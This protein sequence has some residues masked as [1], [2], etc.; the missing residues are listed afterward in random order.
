MFILPH[1]GA[2]NGD[3]WHIQA[4]SIMGCWVDGQPEAICQQRPA[5]SPPGT[6]VLSALGVRFKDH[7]V[8]I[9]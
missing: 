8:C 5:C 7:W 3:T 2:G 6:Q 4:G 9:C 1:L